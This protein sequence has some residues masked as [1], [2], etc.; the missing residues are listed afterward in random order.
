MSNKDSNPL[1]L[2]KRKSNMSNKMKEN[3]PNEYDDFAG[4]IVN[5]GK[6]INMREI[7]IIWLWF[8]IIH[9]ELFIENFLSRISSTTDENKN[10]TMNGTIYLSIIMIIGIIIIDLIYR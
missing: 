5:V 9:S 1:V 10:L 4:V 8:L 7:F 3:Y 6:S 2:E